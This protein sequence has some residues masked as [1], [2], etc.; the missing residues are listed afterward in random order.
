MRKNF[1]T[2]DKIFSKS[3]AATM[4][5]WSDIIFKSQVASVHMHE[6]TKAFSLEVQPTYSESVTFVAN[7]CRNTRNIC[8]TNVWKNVG[9]YVLMPPQ[10]KLH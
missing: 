9:T 3:I 2:C 6:L 7:Y 8:E 10:Q 4:R 5:M 1:P